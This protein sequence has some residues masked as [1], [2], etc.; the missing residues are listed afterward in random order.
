M[1]GRYGRFLRLAARPPFAGRLGVGFVLFWKIEPLLIPGRGGPPTQK[2]STV[3]GS[4]S[5]I[6]ARGHGLWAHRHRRWRRRRSRRNRRGAWRG[7]RVGPRGMLGNESAIATLDQGLTALLPQ[8]LQLGPGRTE[9]P[10]SRHFIAAQPCPVGPQVGLQSGAQVLQPRLL[11]PFPGL[12]APAFQL[13]NLVRDDLPQFADSFVRARPGLRAER[14]QPGCPI[15]Q[16]PQFRR[17]AE[18]VQGQRQI[19][20][21][22]DAAR[23]TFVGG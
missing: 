22:P 15:I 4:S 14:L 1:L 2:S 9:Q 19:G 18:Q 12:L 10:I 8:T 20:V 21:G 13:G 3:G 11:D 6:E 17:Q 23:P 16:V 5:R 7:G